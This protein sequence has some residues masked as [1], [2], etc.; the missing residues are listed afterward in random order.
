MAVPERL[1]V[2]QGQNIVTG[3]DFGYVYPSQTLLDVYFLHPPSTLAVPLVGNLAASAISIS[4]PSGGDSV[5]VVA[6]TSIAWAVVNGRDV[7]RIKTAQPGDFSLY[8]LNIDDQRIDLYYNNV[9]FSF[10]GN[11][12]SDLDCA[13]PPHDCAPDSPVDFPVDYSARPYTRRPCGPWE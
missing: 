10:K 13:P 1:V 11:C 7:L 6:I 3:I 12:P 2:L 8:R 9:W 5:P 4:S